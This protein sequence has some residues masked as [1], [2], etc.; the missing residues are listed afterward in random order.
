[1]NNTIFLTTEGKAKLQSEL[2]ELTG[3]RRDSI[4]RRLKH[5]IEMGDLSENA[6][7]K[8]AK[9]EQSFLEGRIQEIEMILKVGVIIEKEEMVVGEVNIGSRVTVQ[10]QGYPPEEYELVGKNESNP[11]ENK[12]SYESPIGIALMGKKVG[13][14]AIVELPN[15]TKIGLKILSVK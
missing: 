11:R 7:Y 6:D 14:M 2:D 5:A 1:M 3:P 9:E 10:E 15:D 8:M 13:D 12:I 4:A